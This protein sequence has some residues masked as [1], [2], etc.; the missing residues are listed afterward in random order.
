MYETSACGISLFHTKKPVLDIY[1][2]I[3][4]VSLQSRWGMVVFS[5]HKYTR[6][7]MNITY[8]KIKKIH[9][10][11]FSNRNQLGPP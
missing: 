11:D 3:A 4:T 7:T 10:A 5:S 1:F 6:K 2:E 8:V 9:G